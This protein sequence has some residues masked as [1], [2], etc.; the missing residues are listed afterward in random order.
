MASEAD[1]VVALDTGA[2]ANLVCLR[3]LEP[4]N[5]HLGK[6]GRQNVSTYL[7]V[8]RFRFGHRRLGVVRHAADIAVGIAGN[9][10]EITA[11]VLDADV[12]ALLQ[13]GAAEAPGGGAEFPRGALLRKQWVAIYRRENR[14]GRNIL[15]VVDFGGD[16]S[17]N[18]R[19]PVVL[20][21]FF[22]WAVIRKRP[23]LSNG[24]F[25]FPT[26]RMAWADQ[27]DPRTR[28]RLARRLPW[29]MR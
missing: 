12:P 10:G 3:R 15:S 23:N 19:D 6:N 25:T 1:S 7:S 18:M 14:I 17:R 4:R 8:A 20:A 27:S 26:R 22:D 24:G 28:F 29:G 9:N 5:R 2:T 13:K 21:S 16:A 11:C